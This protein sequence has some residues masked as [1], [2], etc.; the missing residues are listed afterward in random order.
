MCR[1]KQPVWCMLCGGAG[2][3]GGGSS[4][5]GVLEQ[6]EYSAR[7]LD[8]WPMLS[9]LA[10][11]CACMRNGRSDGVGGHLCGAGDYRDTGLGR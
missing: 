2:K 8:V 1:E 7:V 11:A 4:S 10:P 6:T 3:M 5:R 9:V